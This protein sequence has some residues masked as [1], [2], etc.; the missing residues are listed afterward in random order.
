MCKLCM[1]INNMKLEHKIMKKVVVKRVSLFVFLS[2]QDSLWAGADKMIYGGDS[3]SIFVCTLH[4][5]FLSIVHIELPTG[6]SSASRSS[7]LI[8]ESIKRSP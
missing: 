7:E 2:G 1:F 8:Y 6:F 5:R 4:Y 3:E